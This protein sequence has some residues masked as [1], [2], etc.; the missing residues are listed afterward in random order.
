MGSWYELDDIS[1][2]LLAGMLQ[3]VHASELETAP[4]SAL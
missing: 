4:E 3:S 1:L 2:E